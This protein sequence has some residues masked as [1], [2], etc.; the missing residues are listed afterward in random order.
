LSG[1]VILTGARLH[2]KA[3]RWRMRTCGWGIGPQNPAGGGQAV[4]AAGQACWAAG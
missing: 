1:P 2:M 4:R 3:D